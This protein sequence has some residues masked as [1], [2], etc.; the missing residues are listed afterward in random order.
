MDNISEQEITQMAGKK[1]EQMS[2]DKKDP[3][4]QAEKE[5]K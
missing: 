1:W 4:V 5:Q 3:Y 2:E